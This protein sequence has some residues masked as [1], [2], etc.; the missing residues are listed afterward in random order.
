[1]EITKEKLTALNE[2]YYLR[3]QRSILVKQLRDILRS[4]DANGGNFDSYYITETVRLKSER[5]DVI[6]VIRMVCE[7]YGDNQ[8]D[9]SMHLGD[10]IDK[11]LYKHLNSK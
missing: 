2:S 11:H 6:S 3:G 1:M 9:E 10:V 4:L 5:E 8:W 7:D